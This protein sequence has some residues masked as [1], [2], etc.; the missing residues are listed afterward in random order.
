[1]VVVEDPATFK[2][3]TIDCRIIKEKISFYKKFDSS[4]NV[5]PAVFKSRFKCSSILPQKKV[6]EK[7]KKNY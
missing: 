3:W 5:A 2:F 1:M 6:L 7:W 4:T